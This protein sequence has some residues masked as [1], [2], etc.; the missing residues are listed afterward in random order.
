MPVNLL[1]RFILCATCIHCALFV[2]LLLIIDVALNLKKKKTI[3]GRLGAIYNEKTISDEKTK[4][5]VPS[6]RVIQLHSFYVFFFRI[7]I[8]CIAVVVN[9]FR[10][11]TQIYI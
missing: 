6:D 4:F 2:V 10:T 7:V 1:V 3:L 11:V 9:L 8:S 5:T